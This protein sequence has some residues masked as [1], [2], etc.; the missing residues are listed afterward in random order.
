ML[1]NCGAKED[2]RVPWTARGSNQLILKDINREYSLEGLSLKLQ[3]FGYLSFNSLATWFEELTHWKRPWC[4]KDWRQKENEKT[5]GE[6]LGWHFWLMDMNL[7]KLKEIMEGRGACHAT[8]R[9]VTKSQI[10]QW[11]NNN[12]N[13]IRTKETRKRVLNIELAYM[14]EMAKLIRGNKFNK[15]W[16]SM[17]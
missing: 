16:W 17:S 9:G 3:Y 7:S 15:L 4:W 5:E 14:S 10:W 13:N 11:L 12:N 8:V 1:S 6:M 2:L